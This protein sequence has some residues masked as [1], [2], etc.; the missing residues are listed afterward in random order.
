MP[1][2]RLHVVQIKPT[3]GSVPHWHTE[4]CPCHPLSQLSGSDSRSLEPCAGLLELAD[5]RR[6]KHLQ[7]TVPH[8][9]ILARLHHVGHEGDPIFR[10]L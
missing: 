7:Q 10:A 5:N 3:T 1:D 6:L 4:A 9:H 2:S 8:H